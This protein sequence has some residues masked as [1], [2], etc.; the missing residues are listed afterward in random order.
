M[1]QHTPGPWTTSDKPGVLLGDQG[2]YTTIYT[3]S[4]S[5]CARVIGED[6]ESRANARLIA[7]APAQND[8][9][10]MALRWLLASDRPRLW[11]SREYD[12]VVGAVQDAIAKAD[13]P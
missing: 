11:A 13:S 4:G 1:T 8:A 6:D 7:A 10:K 3:A 5:W 9:L 12:K 2:K